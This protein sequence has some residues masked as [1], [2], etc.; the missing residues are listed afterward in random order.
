MKRTGR[1]SKLTPATVKRILRSV[2][3]G[4]PLVHA[5]NTAGMTFQTLST[6]RSKNP[7][8]ADA[9][10]QAISKGIDR[11]LKVVEQALNSPDEAIRLRSA[12]WFLEHTAPQ[13]FARN[14]IELTGADGSPLA[15]GIGIYLPRKDGDEIKPLPAIVTDNENEN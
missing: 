1:P 6:H 12:C 9:I 10:A 14:R 8:F 2:E 13:H 11:R 7:A 3:R 15:V 5:A 4:M